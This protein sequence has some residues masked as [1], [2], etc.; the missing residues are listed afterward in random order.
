MCFGGSPAAPQPVPLKQPAQAPGSGNAA[1]QATEAR[2]RRMGIAATILTP[3]GGL[4]APSTSSG[5]K[6]TLGV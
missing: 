3:T 2:R 5:G 1:L 4:G 6:T